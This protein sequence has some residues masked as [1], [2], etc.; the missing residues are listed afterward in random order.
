MMPLGHRGRRL[1][2]PHEQLG[3]QPEIAGHL[4]Q[5]RSHRVV[6]RY[7]GIDG[8]E[9]RESGGR[10]V[11]FPHRDSSVEPYYRTVGDREQLVVPLDDL[12]PVRVLHPS[13]IGMQGGNGGLYLIL[14]QPIPSERRLQNPNSLGYRY[15][16]PA[17]P[18][19]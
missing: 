19:E 4:V 8:G 12:Y 9:R 6:P 14:A 13:R 11:R 18:R 2:R 15:G 16:V 7:F 17:R 1:G 3:R 5:M 10:A